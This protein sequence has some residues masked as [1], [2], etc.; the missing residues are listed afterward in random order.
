MLNVFLVYTESM[1]IELTVNL[2]THSPI[3]AHGY[4]PRDDNY[5]LIQIGEK[6]MTIISD[7][8]A[9]QDIYNDQ[10]DAAVIGLTADVQSLNDLI[11]VLQTSGGAI[12]AEDQSTLDTLDART[13][14]VAD[15]LSAL[16]ALTPP[17]AP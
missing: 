3:G 14:V 1:K 17:V 12:S 16:D 10:I 4:A 8:A 7:F 11:K 6:I 15:K 9:K 2:Y 13:K 5:R